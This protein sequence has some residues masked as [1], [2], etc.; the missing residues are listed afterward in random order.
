MEKV[1]CCIQGT[2]PMP[3][4]NMTFGSAPMARETSGSCPQNFS[5]TEGFTVARVSAAMGP[6]SVTS[7]G[8]N[9][10]APAH[11]PRALAG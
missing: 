8:V 7:C 5:A 1:T 2:S 11:L 3:I 6:S 10:S 9:G 4:L